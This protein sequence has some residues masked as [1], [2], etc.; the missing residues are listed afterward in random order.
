MSFSRSALFG[1]LL[2]VFAPF[3]SGAPIQV[4]QPAPPLPFT[5]VLQAPDGT[6]TDWPSLRG[7]VVVL[8]FWATWCG[9]CIEQIPHLNEL[10]KSTTNANIQFIAVDDEEPAVVRKFISK[11]P[12]DGWLGLDTTK[13]IINVYDAE[14]RPRTVV[15]D[16]QG[17]IAGILRPEQLTRVQLFSLAQ[18]NPVIFP[19][20]SVPLTIAQ[21]RAEADA[22]M[23]AP[24]EGP[25]GP[26]PKPLFDISVRP[27]DPQGKIT[28]ISGA[29]KG[30]TSFRL[31]A[32]N[33]PLMAL[34]YDASGLT[35][36]RFIIHGATDARFT[37]HV[38]A[39][40]GD[41][42]QFGPAIQ[43]A[44]A[45]AAGFKLTHVVEGQDV[46]VLQATPKA[47][48]LLTPSDP[49]QGGSYYDEANHKIIMRK[50]SLDRLATA[51]EMELNSPVVNESGINGAFD[52]IFDLPNVDPV[53]LKAALESNLGL[54][55]VKARRNI[56]RVV[57]D[58]LPAPSNST[59]T[60]SKATHP[61]PDSAVP[62]QTIAIPR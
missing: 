29:P 15:I 37:L 25:N 47:K 5:Q 50:S 26:G 38:S 61:M 48:T 36:S 45:S 60:P 34:F 6:K 21:A 2:C 20:D 33:A 28:F 43:V 59:T 8:E 52:A 12:I 54:T 40:S 55:L 18:G 31:D 4:G 22:G 53:H 3:A 10:I 35:P 19:T 41:V 49:G 23:T 44:L 17:R 42:E 27:G 14:T 7:K 46:W 9:A 51:L 32:L 13:T 62:M 1:V 57:L 56:D 11:I 58:P 39:S 30:D 16:A 24:D